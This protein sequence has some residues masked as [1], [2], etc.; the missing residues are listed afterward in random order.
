MTTISHSASNGHQI[1]MLETVT[2][3]V[4]MLGNLKKVGL[5]HKALVS[6]DAGWYCPGEES[7]GN[8]RGFTSISTN[9]IP[10]LRERGF[11]EADIDLLLIKNPRNAFILHVRQ[12]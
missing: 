4:R 10:S 2:E 11:S 5:L 6:H 12:I 3:T 1:P 8:F 7:G 9:L